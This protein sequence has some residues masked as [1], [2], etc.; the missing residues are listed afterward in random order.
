MMAGAV[1]AV[2]MFLF[3]YRLGVRHGG[4]RRPAGITPLQASN[5][6]ELGKQHGADEVLR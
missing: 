4:E 6:Y 5:L 3:G 1:I 2:A